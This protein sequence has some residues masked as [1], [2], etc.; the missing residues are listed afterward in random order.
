LEING[1]QNKMYSLKPTADELDTIINFNWPTM[2]Q[3]L[4][5]YVIGHIE[6]I[7]IR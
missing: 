3:D 5:E 6:Q 7:R 2:Q 4:K 1:G